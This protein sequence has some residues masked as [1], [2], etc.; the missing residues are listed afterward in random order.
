MCGAM[1]ACLKRPTGRHRL[2]CPLLTQTFVNCAQGRAQQLAA[3]ARCIPRNSCLPC[4]MRFFLFIEVVVGALFI[5]FGLVLQ[6]PPKASV[7]M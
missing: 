5:I 6:T 4:L 1:A 3:M 2:D 7:P